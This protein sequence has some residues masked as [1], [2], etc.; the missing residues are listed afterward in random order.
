[1][2]IR[3]SAWLGE[4]MSIIGLWQRKI[5][6]GGRTSLG[7]AIGFCIGQR[8]ILDASPRVISETG[9]ANTLSLAGERFEQPLM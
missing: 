2:A 8:R 6:F 9:P 1:V 4:L 3:F 5:G 7:V